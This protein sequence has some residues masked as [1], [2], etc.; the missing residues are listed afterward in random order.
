M[1]KIRKISSD[2]IIR[3]TFITGFP[4]ETE[5]EFEELQKFIED[6]EFD[7]LGVFKYSKEEGTSANRLKNS[8]SNEIAEARMEEIFSFGLCMGC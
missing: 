2:N 8:I 6:F 1:E 7:R 4:G 3:T 5:K